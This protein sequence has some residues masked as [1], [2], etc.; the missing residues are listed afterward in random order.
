MTQAEFAEALSVNQDESFKIEQRT[1][2]RA[3]FPIARW[4]ISQFEELNSPVQ[5]VRSRDYLS[6]CGTFAYTAQTVNF[7]SN[8]AVCVLHIGRTTSGRHC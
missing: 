4:R 5:V 3:I 2:I 7:P 6:F 1:E 8:T